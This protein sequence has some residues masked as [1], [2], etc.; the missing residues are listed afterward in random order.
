MPNSPIK[1]NIKVSIDDPHGIITSIKIEPDDDN[2]RDFYS[3]F[4]VSYE[5][6]DGYNKMC[7][8]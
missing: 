6:L 2:H 5:K 8:N 1:S 3:S 4:T 7:G